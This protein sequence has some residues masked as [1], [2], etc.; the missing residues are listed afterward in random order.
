MD[1]RP[2]CLPI[3]APEIVSFQPEDLAADPSCKNEQDYNR[4]YPN[5]YLI[6]ADGIEPASS[7]GKQ[8]SHGCVRLTYWDAKELAALVRPGSKVSFV[9]GTLRSE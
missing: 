6:A 7:D 1:L 9:N 3:N 8:G 4:C 5:L 2:D